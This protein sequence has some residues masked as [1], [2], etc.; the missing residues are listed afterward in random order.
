MDDNAQEIFYL[1][2]TEKVIIF[3]DGNKVFDVDREN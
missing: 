2:S 1:D 3:T